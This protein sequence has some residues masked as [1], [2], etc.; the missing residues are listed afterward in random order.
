[1][2]AQASATAQPGAPATYDPKTAPAPPKSTDYPDNQEG[3]MAF[4]SANSSWSLAHPEEAEKIRDARVAAENGETVE[5]TPAAAVPVTQPEASIAETVNAAEGE[6][7]KTDKPAETPAVS[8]SAATPAKIDEWTAKSPELKAAFEKNPELQ[9]EVM[10]MARGFEAAKAITDIVGTPEEAQF[11]VENANRLVTLQANWMLGAD[12][13][14]AQNAA[15]DQVVE[16]FESRDDQ[17]N[18]INGPDGKHQLDPDFKPFIHK[19]ASTAIQDFTASADGQIASLQAKLQ[20]SYP[21][22][23]ARAADA[24]AL[25]N[26]QYEKAAFDFVMS[27]LNQPS[28]GST[29]LPAL[30]PDATPQQIAFQKQLE[31]QQRDLDAKMGKQSVQSRKTANEAINNE[32]QQHYETGINQAIE[33][34]IAAMKDRGEYLP[35]FILSDKWINPQTNQ[36]TKVSDFGARVYLA[37]NAKING[38]PLHI[39]K[40]RSLESLGAR[41]KE[42]RKAEVT[43]LT[44]LYLPKIIEGRVK[45]IQDGIRAS[46]SKPPATPLGKVAR[47]EPQSQGTPAVSTMD[48]SQIR[49]W[50][51]AEAAKDPGYDSM[52]ARTREQLIITLGAKKRFGG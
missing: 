28:G 5:E 37:L 25:Q 44:N 2:S 35:E 52:D 33:S 46:S 23:E 14:E 26:A 38:N 22:E 15:W 18:P 16:M 36:P 27:K 49:S 17:G 34:H 9:T 30:P 31:D 24:D 8:A 7:S 11:A 3:L 51:E 21:T 47:M 19:A 1:V 13:P 20:G 39:A 48:A 41:G 43:R 12:D 4:I 29:A 32:V 45:E 10:E 6:Q 40:L 42:A 50:A